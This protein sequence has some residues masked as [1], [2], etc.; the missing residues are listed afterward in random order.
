MRKLRVLPIFIL[1][2]LLAACGSSIPPNPGPKPPTP[3][4]P[5]DPSG[6]WQMTATDSNGNTATFGAMFNQVGSTVTVTGS[7]YQGFSLTAVNEPA[8]FTCPNLLMSLSNGTVQNTNQ[9]GGTITLSQALGSFN[10]SGTLNSGGTA[11]TGT[12]SNMPGCAG[13]AAS[14]TYTGESVPSVSGSW[15]G[16]VT[17]CTFSGNICTANGGTAGA[18]TLS[19]TQYDSIYAANGTFTLTNVTGLTSGHADTGASV[20]GFNGVAFKVGPGVLSGTNFALMIE[21][22][23]G[24]GQ[25]AY[26][27]GSLTTTGSFAGL[28]RLYSAPLPTVV[29]GYYNV[30]LTQ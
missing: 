19:L 9:L 26:I 16:T 7:Q 6:N 23:S 2:C 27:A 3:G 15:T 10:F 14:G 18:L 22:A 12:Y 20:S 21:D 30:S 13:M 29:V 1:V 11:F 28:M 17:P 25:V 4:A 5:I 24:D 8:N